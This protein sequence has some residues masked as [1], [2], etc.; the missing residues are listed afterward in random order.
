MLKLMLAPRARESWAIE[1]DQRGTPLSALRSVEEARL[2]A[3][4]AVYSGAES[5]TAESDAV[6]LVSGSPGLSRI[7][8]TF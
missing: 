5:E 8:E 4:T 6:S 1:Y 2:S 7:A 3:Y